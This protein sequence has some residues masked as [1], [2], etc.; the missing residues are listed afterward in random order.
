MAIINKL[1]YKW[2]EDFDHMLACFQ[3]LSWSKTSCMK[4]SV[5]LR[6]KAIN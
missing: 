4:G 2:K 1:K 3:E 5:G 6:R